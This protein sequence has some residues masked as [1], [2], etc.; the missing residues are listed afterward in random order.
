MVEIEVKKLKKIIVHDYSWLTLKQLI[1][2]NFNPNG[3]FGWCIGVVYTIYHPEK[4]DDIVKELLEEGVKH[5][6]N[7]ELA[8]MTEYKSTL[9]NGD[10]LKM[11]V[12][13]HTGNKDIEDMIRELE[14]NRNE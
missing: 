10:N 2:M 6:M 7:V 8:P 5:Y 9:S 13:N 3:S 11:P 4:T 1:D 12:F 14:K